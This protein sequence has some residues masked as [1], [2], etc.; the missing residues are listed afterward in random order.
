MSRKE[1]LD[2]LDQAA[3]DLKIVDLPMVF[4]GGATMPLYV[5]EQGGAVLRET[6]DVDV[7]VEAGSYA[8]F[9]ALE[10]RLWASGF[11]QELT[12]HGPRCRWLKQDR[13]YDIVDIRTDHPDDRWARP[14]GEGLCRH[15]LPSG[16]EIP[17]LGPGRFLA[18]KVAALK[19]RGGRYWYESSDF[20]DIVLI[21]ESNPQLQPWLANTPS[22]A[23]LA[24]A[25]WAQTAILRPGLR[26]D[27]EGTVTHGIDRDERVRVVLER[28][29]WLAFA[30]RP[31]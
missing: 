23:V 22:D 28:L 21:L 30:W 9:A 15:T 4:V 14:S 8:E 26:D 19:Q 18:A 3:V 6:L 13:V 31:L 7:M 16:R 25:E 20:E 17:I 2:R 5:D 29:H 24:V 11:H 1:L 12:G 10:E 27:L